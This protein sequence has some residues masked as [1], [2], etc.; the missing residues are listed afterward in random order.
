MDIGERLTVVVPDDEAGVRLLG[1]PGA[2]GSGARAAV[3][4]FQE[5]SQSA[6]QLCL[7]PRLAFPNYKQRLLIRGAMPVSGGTRNQ[8]WPTRLGRH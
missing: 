4:S 1:G 3:A 5:P 8:D 2:A 7:V 6:R